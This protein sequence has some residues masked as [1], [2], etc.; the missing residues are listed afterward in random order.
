LQSLPLLNSQYVL[1]SVYVS[2]GKVVPC[3]LGADPGLLA[4]SQ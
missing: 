4:V 2:Q 1:Y 3:I